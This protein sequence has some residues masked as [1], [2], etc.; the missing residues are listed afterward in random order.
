MARTSVVMSV[1]SARQKTLIAKISASGAFSRIAAVT[2]VPWPRRSIYRRICCRP[3]GWPSHHI[4]RGAPCAH[5]AVDHR[6]ANALPKNI[7]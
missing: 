2:A 4:R 7:G 3:R 1:A 6:D 5:A